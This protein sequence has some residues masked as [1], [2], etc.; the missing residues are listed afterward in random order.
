MNNPEILKIREAMQRT[1]HQDSGSVPPNSEVRQSEVR[2]VVY[3]SQPGDKESTLL[4]LPK[5]FCRWAVLVKEPNDG[6][7]G[8]SRDGLSI[9]TIPV[10]DPEC[11]LAQTQAREWVDASPAN[12]RVP[13]FMM[14][15]QG[16]VVFGSDN[17]IAVLA[18][19]ER[20]DV[21][22][23]T[24][25]EVAW[26]DAE[27]RG[28]ECELGDRWSDWE[29]D[30]PLGFEFDEKSLD[31]RQHLRQR[32][33]EVML[34]RARLAKIAPHVNC[35][36]I[37]PPTLASQVAER[38]R[39]RARMTHRHEILSDQ[40]EVFE[41]IYESCGQRVSEFVHTRSSNMLEWVIIVLLLVQTL[42]VVFEILTSAAV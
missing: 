31:K 27:L 21:L 7:H 5:P 36:H 19:P 16:T 42:L 8:E 23:K 10:T 13:G 41:K 4:A 38:F 15:L 24:L 30:I 20:L 37:H 35:P 29:S 3:A 14:T 18:A 12:G 28:I 33:G 6:V 26:F 9:L 32:Y 39:D 1:E 11:H 17:R 25:I 2:H 34:M 22:S 40:V